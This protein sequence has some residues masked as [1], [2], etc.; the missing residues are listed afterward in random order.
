[1][2]D[3]W[4]ATRVPQMLCDPPKVNRNRTAHSRTDRCDRLST[5]YLNLHSTTASDHLANDD[6]DLINTIMTSG[7]NGVMGAVT[8]ELR[9]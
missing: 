3:V 2:V 6:Q 5:G 7:Q 8:A 1:M 9:T 4:S